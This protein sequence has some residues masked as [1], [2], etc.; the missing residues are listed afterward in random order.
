MTIP[1]Q[2]VPQRAR[3]TFA[4]DDD[5]QAVRPRL[6]WVITRST[7]QVVLVAPSVG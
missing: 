6:P 5:P 2:A 3:T 4:D 7:C 1:F